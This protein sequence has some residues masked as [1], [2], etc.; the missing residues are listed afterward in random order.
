MKR[1]SVTT[2]GP[3]PQQI[4]PSM[5]AAHWVTTNGGLGEGGG[6]SGLGE[7]GGGGGGGGGLGGGGVGGG[8]LGGGEG[9]LGEIP[10]PQ[11]QHACPACRPSTAWSAK[12]PNL[13]FHPGP[14]V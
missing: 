2:P 13:T 1:G 5:L 7:G 14:Y 12:V 3:C 8:G 10:P 9:G 6:G 11:A 4:W